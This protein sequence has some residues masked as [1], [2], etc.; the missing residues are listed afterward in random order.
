MKRWKLK[1]LNSEH[2]GAEVPLHSN[3]VLGSDE[4]LADLVLSSTIV[5]AQY[6]TFDSD[7]DGVK[8]ELLEEDI[9]LE[10]DG[11]IISSDDYLPTQKAITAGRLCFA[12]RLETEEWVEEL[13]SSSP[14]ISVNPKGRPEPIDRDAKDTSTDSK[15]RLTSIAAMPATKWVVVAVGVGITSFYSYFM[16]KA[17]DSIPAEPAVEEV[18]SHGEPEKVSSQVDSERLG[19]SKLSELLSQAKYQDLNVSADEKS[20]SI[21]VSGYVQDD[22]SLHILKQQIE[23]ISTAISINVYSVEKMEQSARLILANLGLVPEKIERGS[24]PGH[25]VAVTDGDF[26]R[27][28]DKAEKVLLSDIP[29]LLIWEVS[30]SKEVSPLKRLTSMI[31][32]Y[33]FS[34]QL[35]FKERKDRIEIIGSLASPEKRQLNEIMSEFRGRVGDT[36]RL[37]HITPRVHKVPKTLSD[38]GI[39]AVRSGDTPYV[40][41]KNGNRYLVGAR[42][43]NGVNLQALSDGEITLIRGLQSYT[44]RYEDLKPSNESPKFSFLVN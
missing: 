33:S 21:L 29:G 5:S 7:E 40:T 6:I 14:S 18:V 39:A 42:L 11:E 24:K 10:S 35:S 13:Q 15:N 16:Y 37:I 32:E 25:L 36:P 19:N 3:M 38:F 4:E 27:T 30:S 44:L 17:K 9:S 41:F 28:W 22:I 8:V 43:P 23:A 31:A 2:Y 12:L 1:V 34:T 26:S 20:E